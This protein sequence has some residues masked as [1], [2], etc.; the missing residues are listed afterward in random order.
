MTD[1]NAKK[2]NTTEL[3]SRHPIK[4][5]PFIWPNFFETLKLKTFA[6][7][8]SKKVSQTMPDIMLKT[9][10]QP[11]SMM[12][13]ISLSSKLV[14]ASS[15]AKLTSSGLKIS[16]ITPV[17]SN[18]SLPYHWYFKKKAVNKKPLARQLSLNQLFAK[19]KTT[20]LSTTKLLT[21]S[22]VTNP[23]VT[24]PSIKK[25]ALTKGDHQQV[26]T[27]NQQT[28]KTVNLGDHQNHY[29]N[30]WQYQIQDQSKKFNQYFYNFG[31]LTAAF[32][33]NRQAL[34]PKEYFNVA[35]NITQQN[36]SERLNRHN[37]IWHDKGSR[38]NCLNMDPDTSVS[39]KNIHPLL[40]RLT[41]TRKNNSQRASSAERAQVQQPVLTSLS[42]PLVQFNRV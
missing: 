2:E 8:F 12:K 30:Y 35:T 9:K 17:F 40:L 39:H 5:R 14:S 26:K 28:S 25:L 31:E 7:T 29:H 34:L 4:A 3:S 41:G 6:Q 32:K 16:P 19:P 15:C 33:Q 27:L 37:E 20:Q 11:T 10:A 42:E 38:D 36:Y 23:S 21:K 24:K 13:P 18:Y 1:F 22:L